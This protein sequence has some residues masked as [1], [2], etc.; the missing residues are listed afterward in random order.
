MQDLFDF[1]TNNLPL[2]IG[3]LVFVVFT[4]GLVLALR[5]PAGRD[6]L[7]KAAVKLAVAALAF[8]EKWLGEQITSQRLA[9]LDGDV[10]PLHPIIQAQTALQSWLGR[11]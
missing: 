10:Q 7:G 3:L 8:A 4:I 2:V 5:T 1:I 6:T 9:A 11:Q